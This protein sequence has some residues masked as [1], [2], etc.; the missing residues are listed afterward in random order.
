MR[1]A[2]GRLVRPEQIQLIGSRVLDIGGG[3]EKHFQETSAELQIPPL[4]YASVGMTKGRAAIPLRLD[5]R[6]DGQQVPPLRFASV[7]MTPLLGT[8]KGLGMTKGRTAI[9]F[10]FETRDDERQSLHSLRSGRDD[11]LLGTNNGT[12]DDEGRTAIPFIFD[13]TD[14][15]GRSLRCGS[16]VVTLLFRLSLCE[17]SEGHLP[18]II[19]GV[20]S[21]TLGTGS[22]TPRH[23]AS[24]MG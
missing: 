8:D 10:K 22:S 2:R 11:T 15:N 9:P 1:F 20:S 18:T 16:E 23:K 12:R 4:R 3:T 13:A 14:D 19:A 24:C 21:A 7:G 17:S 6:D 5:A